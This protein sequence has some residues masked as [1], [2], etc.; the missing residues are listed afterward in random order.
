MIKRIFILFLLVTLFVT[1]AHANPVPEPIELTILMYHNLHKNTG[2]YSITPE[3]FEKDLAFLKSAGYTGIGIS[4]LIAFVYEG[5][6]LPPKP[7]MLTFD[8]GLYNNYHYGLPLLQEYG[9]KAVISVIGEHSETWSNNFY[10]DL[11]SGHVTWEQISEM[12]DSGCFEIGNHTYGL[13]YIAN[14]RKGCVRMEGEALTDYHRVLGRDLERLQMLLQ[15]NCGVTP[16][17]FAYPYHAVSEESFLVLKAIGIR[18]AF[19]GGGKSNTIT[20]GDAECLYDLRRVN[21]SRFHTA[22]TI[23]N[24]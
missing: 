19:T 2:Q 13:H 5:K 21:R 10:E 3:E 12:V 16:E 24:N 9:F 4:D 8:D 22:E 7:I 23:L 15:E 17:V 18:A 6:P 20:P 1:P 14:G 11:K